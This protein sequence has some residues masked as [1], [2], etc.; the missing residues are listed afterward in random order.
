MNKVLFK[1]I[2]LFFLLSVLI[3]ACVK[4]KTASLPALKK[5]E[6]SGERLWKRVTQ[7]DDYTTCP[8]WPNHEGMQPGQSPHGRYHRIFISPELRAALPI[9]E[10]EVP[11]GSIIVKENYSPDKK[12]AA[13]TLMAKVE[14]YDDKNNDWFWAKYD[15]KGNV[16]AEGKLK[17]CADCHVSSANDYLIVHRLDASLE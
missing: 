16:Q 8:Q 12:L 14:G 10:G 6:I 2:I 5:S 4:K 17:K 13:F 7:E 9:K 3:S 1:V 11:V 15:A